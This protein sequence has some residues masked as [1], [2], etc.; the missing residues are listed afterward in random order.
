MASSMRKLTPKLVT[1]SPPPTPK[2]VYKLLGVSGPTPKDVY[3][4]LGHSGGNLGVLGGLDGQFHEKADTK[5]GDPLAPTHPQG[6]V[7]T[8]GGQ[9]THP[10]P[11]VT[12]G[13]NRGKGPIFA[14]SVQPMLR[15]AGRAAGRAACR[16][17]LWRCVRAPISPRGAPRI[18]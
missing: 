5:V 18:C 6:C 11:N 1:L 13:F 2:D 12:P 10:K 9:W 17:Q 14:A 3:T 4:L 16:C 15:A 8:V 7:Q